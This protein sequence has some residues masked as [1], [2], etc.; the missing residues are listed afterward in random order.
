MNL[1]AGTFPVGQPGPR[2]PSIPWPGPGM[3]TPGLGPGLLPGQGSRRLLR[4]TGAEQTHGNMKGPA[5]SRRDEEM[6]GRVPR[7][8]GRA[9][10]ALRNKHQRSAF[11][12]AQPAEVPPPRCHGAVPLWDQGCGSRCQPRLW[13]VSR[14]CKA[15]G[16][17][18]ASW[19]GE[20]VPR[21]RSP[22]CRGLPGSCT[23]A[24]T[25]LRFGLVSC[26]CPKRVKNF[27]ECL[28][29][30]SAASPSVAQACTERIFA[31]PLLTPCFHGAPTWCLPRAASLPHKTILQC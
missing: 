27:Q 19:G 3:A 13:E 29:H 18:G 31:P 30:V 11:R 16:K 6:A 20:V 2:A 1:K 10:G 21:S 25:L 5:A 22:Q 12:Q 4:G 26:C 23:A 7:S 9:V 24:E 15:G 8:A 28:G 14:T 17:A